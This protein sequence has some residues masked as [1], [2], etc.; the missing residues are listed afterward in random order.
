MA[1]AITALRGISCEC[2]SCSQS[3]LSFKGFSPGT[4][5]FLSFKYRDTDIGRTNILVSAK[6]C[7]HE[8]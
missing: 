3:F 5:V 7:P 6:C 4:P 8:I 2:S 1:S